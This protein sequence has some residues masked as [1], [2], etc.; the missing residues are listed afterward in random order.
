MDNAF[1]KFYKK[2]C[3]FPKFKSKK[4]RQSFQCIGNILI[5]F[6]NHK[7]SPLIHDHGSYW[8]NR[9]TITTCQT[10]VMIDFGKPIFQIVKDCASRA[11]CFTGTTA[12]T[13]FLIDIDLFLGNEQGGKT[14][15]QNKS[16]GVSCE[17]T[18]EYKRQPSVLTWR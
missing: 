14:H 9:T 3:G 16:G 1:T 2:Q 13:V 7:I 10:F 5:S 8:T 15:Q 17:E 6:E 12:F 18:Y 11:C 4:H